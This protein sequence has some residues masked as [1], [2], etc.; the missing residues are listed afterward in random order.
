MKKFL[1]GCA[2][3]VLALVLLAVIAYVAHG[4]QGMAEVSRA[5]HQAADDVAAALP[6]SEQRAD[7]TREEVRA[8]VG[9]R[10]G[11]P[12]YAWRELVCD[13]RSVDAGWI[14][15]SYRQEC[16]VRT[17]DLVPAARVDSEECDWLPSSAL[18]AVQD[19]P[20][21]PTV[22]IMRGPSSAFDEQHPYRKGCPDGILA[23][24][25]LGT[26]RLLSGSRP[27]SL[28]GSPAWVVISVDTQVSS[29]DL[30][31]SPW[32]VVFCSQPV[33]EPVLGDLREVA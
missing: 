22:T 13:L 26:T 23:P 21:P 6:T 3:V 30:G 4:L 15:Q 19:D 31:C 25:Q 5:K 14:V 12:T 24:P 7:R 27:T 16:R 9:G 18:A 17:V 32:G 2:T 8:A 29:T 10:W 33:D 28:D 1:R 20:M 11:Q